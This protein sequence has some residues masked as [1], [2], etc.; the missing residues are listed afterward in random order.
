MKIYL[1][2]FMSAKLIKINNK[3]TFEKGLP[4]MLLSG[5]QNCC[6]PPP[7]SVGCASQDPGGVPGPLR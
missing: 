2:V 6:D 4:K 3:I 1:C 7:Q 5:V